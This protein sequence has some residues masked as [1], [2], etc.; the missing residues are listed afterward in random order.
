MKTTKIVQHASSQSSTVNMKTMLARAV[1]HLKK[2]LVNAHTNS[3]FMI[4][5]VTARRKS[6]PG[7]CDYVVSG[8]EILSSI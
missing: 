3:G 4:R 8:T 6:M 2:E 5:N 7:V 1:H